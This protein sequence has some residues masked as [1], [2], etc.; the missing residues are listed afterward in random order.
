MSFAVLELALQYHLFIL[1][2]CDPEYFGCLRHTITLILIG[3]K[4]LS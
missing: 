1:N 3:E 2:I 4:F